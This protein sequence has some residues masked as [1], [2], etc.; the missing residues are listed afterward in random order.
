M[1]SHV[2][3]YVVV[4]VHV[5]LPWLAVAR[6]VQ[7]S[8]HYMDKI[9]ASECTQRKCAVDYAPE[10]GPEI[11]VINPSEHRTV[12]CETSE[13]NSRKPYSSS[14]RWNTHM[15]PSM[16]SHHR[17]ASTGAICRRTLTY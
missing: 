15:Y 4:S 11:N 12:S 7:Y 6:Q 1:V 10:A 5:E 2:D 16:G 9:N 17:T 14:V 13:I 3:G 8:L